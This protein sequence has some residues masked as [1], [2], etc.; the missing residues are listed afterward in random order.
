MRA[1]WALADLDAGKDLGYKGTPG[2]RK[3]TARGSPS[4]CRRASRSS[5][6]SQRNEPHCQG[7]SGLVWL[8]LEWSAQAQA[9]APVPVALLPLPVSQSPTPALAKWSH[10]LESQRRSTLRVLA[11]AVI[12]RPL[13]WQFHLSALLAA[14][15]ETLL[16]CLEHALSRWAS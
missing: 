4:N 2:A 8:R 6:D 1:G 10:D 9:C 11:A 5:L 12:G 16:T 7:R 3:Q 15:R 14:T 13:L